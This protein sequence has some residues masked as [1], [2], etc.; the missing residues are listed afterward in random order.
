MIEFVEISE[1]PGRSPISSWIW[2][3]KSRVKINIPQRRKMRIVKVRSDE[4]NLVERAVFVLKA[5][6]LHQWKY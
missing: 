5:V 1:L 2:S 3:A 4:R 6:F